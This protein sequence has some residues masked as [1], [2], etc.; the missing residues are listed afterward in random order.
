METI[1]WVVGEGVEAGAEASEEGGP[2]WR[3]RSEELEA[4][5]RCAAAEISAAQARFL[6]HLAEYDRVRGWLGWGSRSALDWLSNHCGHGLGT[7]RTELALAHGLADLPLTRE[8]L[9]RGVLSLDKAKA[10]ASVASPETEEELLGLAQQATANQLARALA[11]ARR[12]L[13]TGEGEA[14]RRGRYL[15]TLWDD[16]GGLVIR[17]KLRPEEG[18]LF[19]QALAAAKEALYRQARSEGLEGEIPPEGEGGTIGGGQAD[20]FDPCADA[21]DPAGAATAD[22]L[23]AMVAAFLA[24][25]DLPAGDTDA[26]QVIVHVD[27]Q[28]LV[29]DG[30]GRAHLEDGPCLSA[31]TVRRLAC[32]ASLL[33]LAEDDRGRPVAVSELA[34]NIPT[35]IRRAVR[36]RDGHCVF[37]GCSMPAPCCDVHHVIY[38]SRGGAHSAA[39]CRTLCSFHHHLVHEGGFAMRVADDGSL[40]FDRP[41]GSVLPSTPPPLRVDPEERQRRRRRSPLHPDGP[42][43]RSNGERMDLGLAV[44][45]L[46]TNGLVRPPRRT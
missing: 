43:A 42:W 21:D 37:P 14:L 13:S 6:A 27:A 38:R 40:E 45:G 34:R 3:A 12:A 29:D 30:E 18:A 19:R 41:D 7:A 35:W 25:P 8:A 11:A 31:D 24:R 39:N 1:E 26:Y 46:I 33:W 32:G 15:H 44:D 22:A 20:R 10:I 2:A 4:E 28:S 23:N 17:G 36:A 5:L 9:A 16:D